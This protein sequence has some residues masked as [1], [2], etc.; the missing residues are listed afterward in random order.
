MNKK[1]FILFPLVFFVLTLSLFGKVVEDFEHF[2]ISDIKSTGIKNVFLASYYSSSLGYSLSFNREIG[3]QKECEASASLWSVANEA[4]MSF[5]QKDWSGNKYFGIWIKD[6]A[7]LQGK[8]AS[9]FQISFNDGD[10]DWNHELGF[11]D[12]AWH[13]VIIYLKDTG[14]DDTSAY[15]DVCSQTTQ[16]SSTTKGF[17]LPKWEVNDVYYVG[18][19]I[20]NLNNVQT[21]KI[22]FGSAN[23][24]EGECLIDNIRVFNETKSTYPYFKE[25]LITYLTTPPQN[26][27]LNFV[28]NMEK[29]SISQGVKF[30][31]N[32]VLVA[33]SLDYNSDINQALLTPSATL[34]TNVTYNVVMDTNLLFS[35]GTPIMENVENSFMIV[36]NILLGKKPG[37]LSFDN[38]FNMIIQTNSFENNYNFS[39]FRGEGTMPSTSVESLLEYKMTP[40]LTADKQ[41][42][43][44]VNFSQL[45]ISDTSQIKVYYKEGDSYNELN[46]EV[47][48][49]SKLIY[50]KSKNIGDFVIGKINSSV[51]I[52]NDLIKIM[53]VENK[54]FQPVKN[55]KMKIDCKIGS[56]VSKIKG[57]I[58]NSSGKIVDILDLSVSEIGSG[59]SWDGLRKATKQPLPAGIYIVELTAYAG[60]DDVEEFYGWSENKGQSQTVKIPVV[61]YK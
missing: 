25:G 3:T 4:V 1:L 32:S 60:N 56:G 11:S 61:I 30:Y 52:Q 40:V 46:S 15:F 28:E 34:K 49:D 57:R 10:E 24:I 16:K 18:N 53:S 5:S 6:M 39:A 19:G 27:K 59:I 44:A 54:I 14:L 33:N 12:D 48:F 41:I 2:S 7:N 42:S 31:T 21:L 51:V 29:A 58:F 37:V 45:N 35:D 20:L 36:T 9:S 38:G 17:S 47:D 23:L 50:F 22:S 55:E 26:I 8:G 13:H 43:F